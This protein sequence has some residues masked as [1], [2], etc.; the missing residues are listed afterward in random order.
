MV[1]TRVF[2]PP[3]HKLQP[4]KLCQQHMH[5]SG[6]CHLPWLPAAPLFDWI[7]YLEHGFRSPVMNVNRSHVCRPRNS[8]C[9]SHN[10][11]YPEEFREM[12]QPERWPEMVNWMYGM[13]VPS[14]LFA[15]FVGYAAYGGYS[16]ANLNLNY[17]SAFM[18]VRRRGR[19]HVVSTHQGK[20]A[21]C[22]FTYASDR[23]TFSTSR[24]V[25]PYWRRM[26]LH[27]GWGVD[28]QKTWLFARTIFRL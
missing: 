3:V 25:V 10:C 6:A 24:T 5:L 20:L 26:G 22:R 9:S 2:T 7:L 27:R 11:R 12:K 13:V 16:Q 8:S 21:V 28:C 4:Y 19:R 1:S 14:Y 18:P 23:N 17:P 15:G